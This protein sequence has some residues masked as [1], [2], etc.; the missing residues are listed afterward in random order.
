MLSFALFRPHPIV[1]PVFFTV[2]HDDKSYV[3]QIKRLASAKRFTLRV[4][5]A[6]RDVVLTI[7]KRSTLRSAHEFAARNA[8]WIG[9]RLDRLAQPIPFEPGAII[10]LRGEDHEITHVFHHRASL[11]IERSGDIKLQK[12]RINV[13]GDAAHI[14]RRVRDY[15]RREAKMALEA[16]VA[17]HCSQLNLKSRSV[18]LRDTTSRWGSCSSQGS[19]NFSW[20]LILAP[21]FVLDY[22]AAHEVAHLIHLDHSPQFWEVVEQLYPNYEQAE[23]WLKHHGPGLYRYGSVVKA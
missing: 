14:N 11:W 2:V 7:P 9:A 4:R 17:R 5:N 8:A 16:S 6:Q 15:L 3:V 1:E 13:S 12:N 23:L 22:L 19:L 20:R 18:T 10:P 21:D